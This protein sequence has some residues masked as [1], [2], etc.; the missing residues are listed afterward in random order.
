MNDPEFVPISK[1]GKDHWSTFAY[2]DTLLADRKW[3]ANERMRCNARRHR[4]FV[5]VNR[6]REVQDGSKYPTR[7]NDGSEVVNHDDW[8][9]LQDCEHEG[10]LALIVDE[11]TRRGE[12][13]FGGARARVE[14]TAKGRAISSQLRNFK[15]KGGNFRE[16][17]PQVE[18]VDAS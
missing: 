4:P 5:H 18:S 3:I 11:D 9:C 10:L 14:L 7:L 12:E 6:F 15:A 2:V 8:D 13:V 17:H 1:F 16:F